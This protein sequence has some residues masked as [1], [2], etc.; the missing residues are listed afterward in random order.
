MTSQRSAA[1]RRVMATLRDLGP[2]KLHDAEQSR[3]RYAADCL[4]FCDELLGSAAARAA[5]EDLHDLTERLVESGRWT[6]E[7]AGRLFDD[8]WSCGPG[9]NVPVRA[10]A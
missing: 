2:A 6:A 4:L 5:L 7:R 9:V 3:I 10:A 1:Y 8:V